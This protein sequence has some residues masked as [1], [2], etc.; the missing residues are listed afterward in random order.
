LGAENGVA[1]ITQSNFA[2]LSLSGEDAVEIY[3]TQSEGLPI[4]ALLNALASLW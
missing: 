1:Q 3:P 4:S 2:N